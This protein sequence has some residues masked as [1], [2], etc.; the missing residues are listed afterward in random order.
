MS[1]FTN[2]DQL[3]EFSNTMITI[4][5]FDGVHL[6]HRVILDKLVLRAK[7][8][9]KTSILVTFEP[10]PRKLLFPEKPIQLLT[11]VEEKIRLI[12]ACGIDHIVVVP[13]TH[14]FAALD[15]AAYISDFLVARFHPAAIIIGYDHRFGHDRTGDIKLLQKMQDQYGFQVYEIPAQVIDD[16]AVSS[17]KIRKAL[18]EGRVKDAAEMLGRN[19]TL[20]GKVVH[21]AKLGTAIGFPTANIRP[22]S[23]E[24]QIPAIGIYAVLVK[25]GEQLLRG[26][27]S[28]GY[29]PTVTDEQILRLEVNILDFKQQIYGE[30]LEIM[31]I[32]RLRDE[33]KFDSLDQLTE[34]LKLDEINTRKILQEFN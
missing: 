18:H 19:Y 25:Y 32:E 24:Q 34:Q 28:I 10:H 21:G 29:N 9:Q 1:V 3:P 16:A 27:M 23:G 13:F 31:F 4:G 12:E 14:E 17:T 15:A 7:S 6:G 30:I 26:M 5:T 8:E 22:L 11:P 2:I 33:L 20:A